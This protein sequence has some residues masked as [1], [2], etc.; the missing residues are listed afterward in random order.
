MRR[1]QPPSS[2]RSHESNHRQELQPQPRHTPSHDTRQIGGNPTQKVRH[3]GPARPLNSADSPIC[4]TG[5]AQSTRPERHFG[6]RHLGHSD[7]WTKALD[8]AG[9]GC[10]C[11]CDIAPGG[12]RSVRWIP[13]RGPW[14]RSGSSP[15]R[16]L[17][18]VEPRI[19]HPSM[20]SLSLPSLGS[21]VSQALP[22]VETSLVLRRQDLSPRARSAYEAAQR[23]GA[24]SLAP[25]TT[26]RRRVSTYQGPRV[27]P[28]RRRWP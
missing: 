9:S 12:G 13:R 27:M 8:N 15:V 11:M 28:R 25:R 18:I 22:P 20:D 2:D 5:S 19:I 4:A 17:H 10:S 23:G 6:A 24:Q 7:S 21:V 26:R 14:A 16:P 3:N 1:D